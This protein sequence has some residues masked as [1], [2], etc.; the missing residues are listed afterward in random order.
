[1]RI[2]EGIIP[3]PLSLY[4][5]KSVAAA[6]IRTR[7]STSITVV[8]LTRKVEEDAA[9]KFST[10]PGMMHWW[11]KTDKTFVSLT[12]ITGPRTLWWQTDTKPG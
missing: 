2:N 5:P 12:C 11:D 9:V 8:E 4:S 6:V 1:M 10:E 7:L 3:R